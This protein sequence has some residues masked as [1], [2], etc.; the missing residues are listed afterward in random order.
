MPGAAACGRCSTALGLATA[1]IDVHPP[2]ARPLAKRL[3]R[4]LPRRSYMRARDAVAGSMSETRSH[5]INGLRIPLPDRATLNRLIVPGWAHL[6]RGF[7][8]RG[9]CFL[10][11][12]LAL[13][14]VGLVGWGTAGASVA[15]G[16]AFSVH[17]AATLDVLFL[18]GG[19]RFPSM[20]ATG[21][22]TSLALW[23]LVYGPSLWT[24]EHIAAPTEF[25]QN[26]VP[27]ARG[28]VILV[29]RWAFALRRPQPGDVVSYRPVAE[30]VVGHREGHY[31][32]A[33]D[34]P[35][36]IDR[37]LG[38]PGDHIVWAGG[39]LAINGLKTP[40]TPLNL[41][42]APA[43]LMLIVPNDHYLI[44][45]TTS[46]AEATVRRPDEWAAVSL[47][48]IPDITGGAYLR[49]QPFNRL[50]LIR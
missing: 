43:K 48:P 16:L 35:E 9:A 13:V 29:N 37:I 1:V 39:V 42:R 3:R 26:V 22:F 11:S 2:R 14:F 28:D 25:V 8:I 31:T 30:R 6:A 4:I 32:F 46:M 19:M 38:A 18:R 15:L 17:A 24:L 47:V 12:W 49:A 45:P 33:Y 5:L 7:R 27:F 34:E 44:L 40:W 41:A 36:R 23:A 20:V 21:L 50:W 10:T